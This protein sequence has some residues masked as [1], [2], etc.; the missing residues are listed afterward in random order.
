MVGLSVGSG[1]LHFYPIRFFLK[2]CHRPALA[3]ISTLRACI[4]QEDVI[5]MCA[6][7]L[8]GLGFASE[9]AVAENEL[10]RFGSIGDVEL[11]SKFSRETLLVERFR[12]AKF[13]ENPAIVRQKRFADVE[14]RKDFLFQDEDFSSRFREKGGRRTATGTA[15]DYD[16]VKLLRCH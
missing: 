1:R 13:F 4:L 5:E 12:K 7:D 2:A 8:D 9:D 15:A 3:N 14:P 10:H 16:Y 11:R 6:L